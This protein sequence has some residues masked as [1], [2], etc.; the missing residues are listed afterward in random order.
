MFQWYFF[1]LKILIVFFWGILMCEEKIVFGFGSLLRCWCVWNYWRSYTFMNVIRFS[2]FT[3]MLPFI[4]S[5]SFVSLLSLCSVCSRF[6]F[7]FVHSCFA[8]FAG[9][10]SLLTSWSFCAVEC[11]WRRANSIVHCFCCCRRH[12]R[13]FAYLRGFW[14]HSFLSFSFF[15]FY[16]DLQNIQNEK[17]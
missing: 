2:L 17:F 7:Y 6:F 1:L 16:F 8:L 10:V 13:A 3:P 14:L 12:H 4:V 5:S 9:F 11:V 15:Y